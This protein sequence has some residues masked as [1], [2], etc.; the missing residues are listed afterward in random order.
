M[1]VTDLHRRSVEGFVAQ[2]DALEALDADRWR[3]PT[4]C[5]EWDVRA[6][7]NHVA[8]EDLWT[9]PL[10]EGATM[11]EVGNRFDGDLLGDDPVAIA[12]SACD[13][14]TIAA[15]SGVVAGQTVH[16]SFGDTPADE[17]AYQLAADHLIHG[18]DLAAATGGERAIDPELVEA[19][20]AWFVE[21]EDLYRGAGVIAA[22][23][24]VGDAEPGDPQARLLLAFGRDPS[25]RSA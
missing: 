14:A 7:V 3:A 20:A 23:P 15:A 4:P 8:N 17:Y 2:L 1:H 22:R 19:C 5:D 24:D 11:D 13:A 9:V 25:W 18:W 16:L 6:L 12:R 21:R 10:M